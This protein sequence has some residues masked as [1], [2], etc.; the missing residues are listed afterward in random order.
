MSSYVEDNVK[1]D[2]DQ[3]IIDIADYVLSKIIDSVVA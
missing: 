1:P 2:Y 3:V